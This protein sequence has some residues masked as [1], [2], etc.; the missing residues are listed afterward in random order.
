[1]NIIQELNSVDMFHEMSDSHYVW[2]RGNIHVNT[3]RI[4]MAKLT[5]DQLQNIANQVTRHNMLYRYF[6]QYFKK[7]NIKLNVSDEYRQ[8]FEIEEWW[9]HEEE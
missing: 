2:E 1:M 3:I 5:N 9:K 6:S 7:A 8:H 4:E